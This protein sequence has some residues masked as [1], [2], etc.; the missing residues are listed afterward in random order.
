MADAIHGTTQIDATKAAAIAEKAQR[1]LKV[2]ARLASTVLDVSKYAKP[3]YKTISFPKLGSFTVSNRTSGAAGDAQVITSTVDTMDLNNP[4]Y[5]AWIIDSV[6]ELQSS[7]MWQSEL[8]VRAAGAHGRF[9][10]EKILTAL[11]TVAQETTT[12]GN[13]S[14]AVAIELRQNMVNAHVNP[15]ECTLLLSPAQYS[16]ALGVDEFISAEKYGVANLP[17]GV[18]GKLFGL[19]VMEYAGL[20]TGFYCYHKEGL[21]LGFQAAPN[22]SKQMA[23]EYGT[24]AERVAMD[25]LFGVKGL[26]IA[27]NGAASGKSAL[28]FSYNA[29]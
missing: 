10:D 3:G 11:A 5:L 17:T 27:Q 23:N 7:I 16:L 21:A 20:S 25:Q 4:A 29:A 28:V 6:D 15:E 13:I 19:N 9:V 24:T 18:I 14:K 12:V 1:E 22:M 2:K 8:A 26:Q